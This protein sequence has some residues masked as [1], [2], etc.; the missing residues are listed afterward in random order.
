MSRTEERSSPESR[1]QRRSKDE[2][3]IWRIALAEFG[4]A[5]R[6][7]R[8]GASFF[9]LYMGAM[10]VWM[11]AE[12]GSDGWRA[13]GTWGALLGAFSGILI[14]MSSALYQIAQGGRC[15]Y[16][17]I[18]LDTHRLHPMLLAMPV[19]AFA[20]GGL[21]AGSLALIVPIAFEV[22]VVWAAVAASVLAFLASGV[23]LS[24]A[25]RFLYR[26][27]LSQTELAERARAEASDAQL[28]AL[29]AQLE[30]HFLFNALNTVASLVRTDPRR[31]EATVENLA[32]ILRRTLDRS[33]KPVIPLADE[34]DYLRAYLSIEKERF[35]DRLA[36][37]WRID[38]AALDCRIPPMSLQP[39][40]ENSL[41][42]ALAPR[43]SGGVVHIGAQRNNG[44]LR[45]EVADDGPGFATG[46]ADGTGLGN[47]RRRLDTLYGETARLR[48]EATDGRGALVTLDLPAQV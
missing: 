18:R 48:V 16:W 10:T 31:A 5:P 12:P 11:L 39:L 25:T 38:P 4:R 41:K 40:V 17:Q 26:H 37:E 45:L 35:G 23:A 21:A 7:V 9:G 47:L 22:P 30:P 1:D 13:P 2:P 43:M 3:S 27:A 15:S 42:H 44:R 24:D 19:L 33:R 34:L 28:A 46:H 36:V 32:R 20:G 6:W 29:Q 14:G 8:V